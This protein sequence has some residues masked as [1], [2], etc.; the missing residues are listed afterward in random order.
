[1]DRLPGLQ[2]ADGD[3]PR[4]RDS[5]PGTPEQLSQFGRERVRRGGE[6]GPAQPLP[7]YPEPVENS[8]ARPARGLTPGRV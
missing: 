5:F 3:G 7:Q 2:C 8:R 6:S 4:G 1:L